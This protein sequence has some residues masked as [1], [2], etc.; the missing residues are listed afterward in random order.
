LPKLATSAGLVLPYVKAEAMNL[1]L[2]EIS[3]HIA[4][5]A[6]SPLALLW[7]FQMEFRQNQAGGF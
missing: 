3:R 5:G 4:S 7:Q 2:L 6:Y 1:P